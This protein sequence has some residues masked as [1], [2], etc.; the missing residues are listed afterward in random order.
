MKRIIPIILAIALAGCSTAQFQTNLTKVNT[1]ANT[2]GP[3]VGKDLLMI[4]NILVQ[5]E[6]SPGLAAGSTVAGNVLSIIAPHSSSV[7]TVTNILNTNVQ[8][9]AQ[10]CPF[11]VALK[12]SVGTVPAGTPSQVI[13]ANP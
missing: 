11:I 7:S 8:V 1:F 5:A 4:A 6:C 3:I 13:P 2:Y 12:A 10:L 9:A